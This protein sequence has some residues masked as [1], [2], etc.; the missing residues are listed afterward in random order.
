MLSSSISTNTAYTT[1]PPIPISDPCRCLNIP[2][3]SIAVSNH[4]EDSESLELPSSLGEEGRGWGSNSE[5]VGEPGYE[6]D[7]RFSHRGHLG[8]NGTVM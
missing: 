6:L 4:S 2:L 1:D 8:Y 5:G 3:P 7:D